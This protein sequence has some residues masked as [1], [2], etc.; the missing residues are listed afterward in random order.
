MLLI[1]DIHFGPLLPDGTEDKI[2]QSALDDND[3]LVLFSG[4]ITQVW[5]CACACAWWAR[6][7]CVYRCGYAC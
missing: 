1:S 2:L 5:Y 6:A 4:D 7:W 3:K